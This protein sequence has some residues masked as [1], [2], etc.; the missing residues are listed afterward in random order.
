MRTFFLVAGPFVGLALIAIVLA[1]F[2]LRA[3]GA[4]GTWARSMRRQGELAKTEVMRTYD[5]AADCHDLLCDLVVELDA[6]K[7]HLPEEIAGRL[8]QLQA[9]PPKQSKEI[10]YPARRRIGA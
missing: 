3:S 9:N 2:L 10:P 7:V 5:Y 8:Y 6:E 4:L 1:A